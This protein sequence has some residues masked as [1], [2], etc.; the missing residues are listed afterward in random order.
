[1]KIKSK[2]TC[3]TPSHEEIKSIWYNPRAQPVNQ[4]Y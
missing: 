4:G 3:W 1:M 2:H